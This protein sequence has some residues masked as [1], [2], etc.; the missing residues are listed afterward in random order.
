ML[1]SFELWKQDK[2]VQPNDLIFTLALKT[3]YQRELFDKLART[4]ADLSPSYSEGLN[5]L[6]LF[7]DLILMDYSEALFMYTDNLDTWKTYLRNLRYPM[8]THHDE[9]LKSKLD[10]LIWPPGTKTKFERRGDRAG[11]EVKFFISSKADIVKLMASLE[12]IQA[13]INS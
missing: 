6:E 3:D 11:I 9:V 7:T 10:N 12:R 4:L 5:M 8:T 2:K 13:E 1:N